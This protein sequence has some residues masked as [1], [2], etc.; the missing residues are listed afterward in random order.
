MP[1]AVRRRCRDQRRLFDLP[2]EL[3]FHPLAN[4][5]RSIRRAVSVALRCRAFGRCVAVVRRAG[6]KAD[7]NLIVKVQLEV[8]EA[9]TEAQ[10]KKIEE[11]SAELGG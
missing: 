11:L 9:L 8:P 1:V 3:F 4:S 2:T 6:G 10:R 7:G 5:V